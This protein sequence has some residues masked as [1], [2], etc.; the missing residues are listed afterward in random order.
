MAIIN[1]KNLL[2]IQLPD[3]LRGTEEDDQINGL[4][5]NDTIEGRGG[6]DIIDGGTGNDIMIGGLGNDRYIVDSLGDKVVELPNQGIDTVV[7]SVSFSLA[8]TPNVENLTLVGNALGG[9]GNELNNVL[10]GNGLNNSLAG[11]DGDDTIAGLGGDDDLLG[12]SGNDLLDGGLGNDRMGGSIGDD[13]YIVDSLGDEINENINEGIDT[14]NASISY[15]LGKNLENLV[16]T[17]A[18]NIDGTGNELNNEIT[19]NTGN[20]VLRGLG[21]NDVLIGSAGDDTLD[22]GVGDDRMR[23]GF[24]NDTYIVDSAGD[25]VTE[26][27]NEGI[28]TIKASV[29]YT[30]SPN[31][32]KLELVGT[33]NIDGT[34]NELNNEIIGNTGNNVLRGLDG[35]D[36]LNGGA[37]NDTLD[38][39]NGTDTL[40]GGLGDDT[41]IVSD[42]SDR[43]VE[44]AN[45]GVDTVNASISYT[46][47]NNLENLTLTGNSNINGTG[48]VLNNTLRGNA[49]NN[50]LNGKEGNDTLIGGL[51]NDIYIVNDAGDQ[52]TEGV[53]E[54]TDVILASV[55]Y[56][57]SD[58]VEHLG[59]TGSENLNATG[60]K[61]DNIIVGNAGVN[62]LDGGAGNDILIGAGGADVLKGGTGADKFGFTAPTDK[63]DRIM[64]FSRQEGD[65]IVFLTSGFSGLSA[66]NIRRNQF[67]LGKKAKDAN[68]RLIYNKKK[69]ELFYD[70]D[71]KG[72]AAQVKIATFDN[73]PALGARD[74]LAVDSPSASL[75]VGINF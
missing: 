34:G 17:S 2:G 3:F 72:G 22:G 74:F 46:L 70:A 57:L 36:A 41:Y 71:G 14:V 49:G 30:L 54:G 9:V 68:D 7:S 4:G 39:G 31:V 63:L 43:I 56:T 38:G 16:L 40:T 25:V 18:A 33:A 5:A 62:T 24:D 51:G 37:G 69:G 1:G 15:T 11:N 58:N 48:N 66:G 60:N 20:N 28:D 52:V 10:I 44:E 61:L 21:G 26:L 8:S 64:D 67:V 13:T 53:N 75:P 45:G 35:D 23:G 73:K 19:G 42:V 27:P 6:N 65:K 59:L 50:I 47:G 32:E 55:S 12:G 29:S